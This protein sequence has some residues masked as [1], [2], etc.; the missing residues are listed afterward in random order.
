MSLPSFS[1]YTVIRE[2]GQGGMATVYLANHN[3]LGHHVAIKVLDKQFA[4]NNNIKARFVE[5]AKKLVRL[6]H[7]NVV[8][9]TD[10]LVVVF[11]WVK[12][13]LSNEISSVFFTAI[14]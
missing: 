12:F 10:A 5:E 11:N 7:P 2:L 4:F 8:K 14:H 3:S 1:N 6:D 13:V 9:V